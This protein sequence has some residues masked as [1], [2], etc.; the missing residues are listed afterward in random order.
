MSD[1]WLIHDGARVVPCTPAPGYQE[2]WL[3]RVPRQHG[4]DD[5]GVMG[6]APPGTPF[7]LDYTA[8][9]YALITAQYEEKK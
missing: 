8:K 6:L 1:Q 3:T 7:R 2:Q 9:G 4:T 5:A